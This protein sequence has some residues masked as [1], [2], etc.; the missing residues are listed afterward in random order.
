VS[1]EGNLIRVVYPWAGKAN[2][3]YAPPPWIFGRKSKL[4]GGIKNIKLI[5]NIQIII[6]NYSSVLNTLGLFCEQI[7]WLL[8]PTQI[9]A[10]PICLRTVFLFIFESRKSAD[11]WSI[12]V[13]F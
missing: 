12:R 13:C 11:I 7:F 3:I 4:K 2:Q 5:P 8:T 10:V 9:L 1:S 6:F